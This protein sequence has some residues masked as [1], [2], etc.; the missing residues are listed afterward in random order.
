LARPSQR[1]HPGVDDQPHGKHHVHHQTSVP[2]V[3]IAVDFHVVA[4]CGGVFA[5]TFD[6]GCVEIL[7]TKWW[8]ILVLLLT[9]DLEMVAGNEVMRDELRRDWQIALI[10]SRSVVVV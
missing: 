4:E 5:P 2:V 10:E 7:A 8:K 9:R 1:I 6:K 3:R